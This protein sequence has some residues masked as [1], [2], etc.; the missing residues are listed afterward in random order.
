MNKKEAD[1]INRLSK[2]AFEQENQASEDFL[3]DLNEIER[4]FK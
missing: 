2:L 4:N 3:F 1:I